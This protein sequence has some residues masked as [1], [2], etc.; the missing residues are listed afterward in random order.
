MARTYT[1]LFGIGA[2]LLVISLALPHASDRDLGVMVAVAV[3]AYAVA[4]GFL[5]G[6][7]RLPPVDLSG[8]AAGRDDHQIGLLACE[9]EARLPLTRSISSGWC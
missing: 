3:A 8:R 5:I 4:A 6:F 2:T 9:I 7:D 1:Y